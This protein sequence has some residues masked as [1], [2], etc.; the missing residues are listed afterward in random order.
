MF[1]GK[2]GQFP[3]QRGEDLIGGG[4]R[5]LQGRLRRAAGDVRGERHFR[6]AQERMSV[7]ERLGIEGIDSGRE[8]MPALE[9]IVQ[10]EEI[11]LPARARC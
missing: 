8:Q 7:R 5:E 1:T 4:A 6:I 10:R 9:R 3:A 2:A 11:Q